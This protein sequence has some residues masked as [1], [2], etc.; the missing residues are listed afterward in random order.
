MRIHFYFFRIFKFILLISFCVSPTLAQLDSLTSDSS[1]YTTD[2]IIVT[3]TKKESHLS[4]STLPVTV[5]SND[6]IF[7]QS[8][9]RLS[10]ILSEQVGLFIMQDHGSGVQMQGLDPDYVLILID[11]EPV[12]GKQA[13]AI[14]LSRFSVGNI[15]QIEIVKGPSSSLYGSD[16]LAGVINIITKKPI[17]NTGFRLSAKY[18]TFNTTELNGSFEHKREKLGIYLF[19]DRTSSSG[20]DF[21]PQSLSK[22]APGYYTYTASPK[23]TFKLGK[24]TDLTAEGRFYSEVIKNVYEIRSATRQYLINDRSTVNDFSAGLKLSR[25]FGN[26]VDLTGS[27]Y[28]A[29]YYNNDNNVYADNGSVYSDITFRQYYNKAEFLS[30]LYLLKNN[31]QTFGGGIINESVNADYIKDGRKSANTFYAF[32][33]NEFKP[34]TRLS[35]IAGARF[36]SGKDYESRFSPKISAMYK[37]INWLTLKAS[38]GSGYKAPSFQQLYLDWNNPI[39]G[40]SVYG[41]ANF[42]EGFQKLLET[43]QI[44]E[45]LIDPSGVGTIKPEI[46]NAFNAAVELNP[47]KWGGFKINFFRNDIENLIDVV[48]VARKTNGQSVFTYFNLNKVYTQGFESELNIKLPFGLSFSAG[49]QYLEAYDKEALELIRQGKILKVGSTGVIRPVQE[50]E[51]GGLFGR[52]KHSGVFKLSYQNDAFGFGMNLRA[53]VRSRYGY[54]DLNSNGILDNNNEY[55]PGY[56]MFNSSITKNFGSLI[57]VQAGVDNILDR[58][59]PKLMPEYPGRT[60]FVGIRLDYQK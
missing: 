33:Q 6:E 32:L 20:Y 39:A 4:S 40:Y 38:A 57:T 52:S 17:L 55:I 7:H 27:F 9:V 41:V 12:T 11:G 26:M 51:Y 36:D 48:Q 42:Q 29:G 18:G 46:S 10:D 49:Y 44:A 60:F 25:R 34:G 43:G 23:I 5:I 3:D 37:P 2:P 14:D 16:A 28:F 31:I 19:A 24:Q 21:T 59:D 30:H 15:Q 56:A 54:A 53:I 22:T 50:V 13:G 45:I 8:A 1:K 47:Y 35:F 58:T